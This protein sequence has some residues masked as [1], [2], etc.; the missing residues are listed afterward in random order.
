MYEN[1]LQK[2][3]WEGYY[4]PEAKDEKYKDNEELFK[5]D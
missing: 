1:Y 2:F 3:K 5:K 4:K